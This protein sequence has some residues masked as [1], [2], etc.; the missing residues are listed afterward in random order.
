MSCVHRAIYNSFPKSHTSAP[1][2]IGHAEHWLPA[3]KLIMPLQLVKLPK[4][5][6]Y[7]F[8]HFILCACVG[9]YTGL[10]LCTQIQRNCSTIRKCKAPRAN[11]HWTLLIIIYHLLF[12]VGCCLNRIYHKYYVISC[13]LSTVIK[14]NQQSVSMVETVVSVNSLIKHSLTDC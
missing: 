9:R 4:V 10:F 3:D 1:L 12:T 5:G 8:W 14:F 11:I 6:A 2:A 7:Y 13:L